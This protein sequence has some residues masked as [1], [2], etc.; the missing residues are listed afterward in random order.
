M[1]K[2]DI[3]DQ[4]KGGAIYVS[5]SEAQKDPV[6]QAKSA[7][8]MMKAVVAEAGLGKYTT[9]PNPAVGCAIIRDFQLL[10]LGHHEKAGQP[11]AEVMALRRA[12]Y[13]VKGATC[14]VSLEPCSHYGRTPP[15]AQALCD[16]KVRKVV[17]ANADPNPLV[18]GRGIKMLRD[19]GIEVKVGVGQE[20]AFEL[21]RAFFTAMSTQLPFVVLKYG[22]SLDAKVAL[23]TGESKWITNQ[24]CRSDVQALRLWA[25]AMITS[26]VTVRSDDPKLNVR[27]NDLPDNIK[28]EVAKGKVRQPIKVII[29]SQQTFTPTELKKYAIFQEGQ[30][31]LV[32]GCSLEELQDGATAPADA[33]ASTDAAAPTDA[34]AADAAAAPVRFKLE[35]QLKTGVWS[36]A[37]PWANAEQKHV[38]LKAVLEFLN[39]LQVRVAMVEA[40][41]SLG[42]AFMEQELVDELYCYIA[43]KILGEGAQAAFKLPEAKLL[44]DALNFTCVETELLAGDVKLRMQHAKVDQLRQRIF[45]QNAALNVTG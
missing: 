38:D 1:T 3:L 23:S 41:A 21:N 39:S 14:F 18:A 17:I 9:S 16:A 37:V 20:E 31:Y 13:A 36:V 22:M 26:G 7:Q 25:D 42:S 19:A 40:G 15:C 33:A 11:H 34:S 44:K 2:E 24:A 29:D 28:V 4:I 12:N 27:Y 10:G 8:A 30:T 6:H 35:R 32:H 43:P 5:G 45:A